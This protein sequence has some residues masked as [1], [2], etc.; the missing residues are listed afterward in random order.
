MSDTERELTCFSAYDKYTRY[1]VGTTVQYSTVQ[2]RDLCR[3]GQVEDSLVVAEIFQKYLLRNNEPFLF[4]CRIPAYARYEECSLFIFLSACIF[5]KLISL[6]QC[7]NTDASYPY[8]FSHKFSHF[9]FVVQCCKVI[10]LLPS[11][12]ASHVQCMISYPSNIYLSIHLIRSKVK[13]FVEVSI[14]N[15]HSI[16]ILNTYLLTVTDA[17]SEAAPR[18]R[19]S[20]TSSGRTLSSYSSSAALSGD[21][22]P[23][24]GRNY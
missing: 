16:N 24:D 9:Y 20:L 5:N 11:S 7:S 12:Y 17:C 6:Q 23:A 8:H 13:Y 21:K 1:S 4:Y 18:L 14:Y 3:T 15:L 2:Y 10:Y 22:W 19:G